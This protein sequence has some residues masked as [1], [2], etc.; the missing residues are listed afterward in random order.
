MAAGVLASFPKPNGGGNWPAMLG[1]SL[2]KLPG[3]TSVAAIDFGSIT[4]ALGR[5]LWVRRWRSGGRNAIL[6]A[7]ACS[8]V[9]IFSVGYNFSLQ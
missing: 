4:K 7:V 6:V 3:A 2:T 8:F 9:V 5:L 1:H